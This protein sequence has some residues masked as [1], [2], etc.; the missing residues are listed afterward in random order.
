MKDRVGSAQADNALIRQIQAGTSSAFAKLE[1]AYTPLM[2]NIARRVVCDSDT[3]EDILQLLRDA[4]YSAA[5]A[6]RI[7]RGTP[8]AAYAK[9]CLEQAII[10]IR[11]R[12]VIDQRRRQNNPSLDVLVAQ[13]NATGE[14]VLLTDDGMGEA[15]MLRRVYHQQSLGPAMAVFIR[16]LTETQR[17]VAMHVFGEG[18]SQSDAAVAMRVSRQAVSRTIMRIE[19]TGRVALAEF[20]C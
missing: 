9:A 5:R 10:R 11:K 7:E 6:F 20:A 16:S 3:R 1:L 17:Q 15:E 8:F 18:E 14:S 12:V 13:S 4:L 2:E 19:A